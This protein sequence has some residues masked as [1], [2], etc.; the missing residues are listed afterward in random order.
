MD[1]LLKIGEFARD[2]HEGQ[3]R[4]FVD[5]PYIT[6]P[7]RVMQLCR[8][9]GL[10]FAA[11]AAAL[12]HDVLEDTHVTSDQLLHFLH[13]AIGDQSG[14]VHALVVELTD[15][16]TKDN[17]PKWNRRKRKEMEAQRA[18]KTS[19]M[20]QSVKYADIMDNCATIISTEDDFG[21]KYCHECAHILTRLDEGDAGLYRKVT[22]TVE[23]SLVLLRG[24]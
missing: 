4:K 13:D 23:R 17:Y 16:Y 22:E 19:S 20:A 12:L 3:R 24:R 18:W 14:P 10:P 11:Q 7:I 6:H 15:E 9:A 1:A 5:E 21:F 2:A 8:E